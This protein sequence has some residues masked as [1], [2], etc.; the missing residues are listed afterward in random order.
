MVVGVKNK[1][2]GE[3]IMTNFYLISIPGP[4]PPPKVDAK[5]HHL[6]TAR[7]GG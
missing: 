3:I 7:S 5:V 2:E 1:R 4:L 6:Y